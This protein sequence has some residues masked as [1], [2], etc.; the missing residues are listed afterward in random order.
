[1]H[2]FMVFVNEIYNDGQRGSLN[3][4]VSYYPIVVDFI[5]VYT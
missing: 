3:E 1:M 4:A 2:S 5:Y